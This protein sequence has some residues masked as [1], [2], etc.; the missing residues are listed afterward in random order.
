MGFI[1]GP[2]KHACLERCSG[3]RHFLHASRPSFSTN[4]RPSAG[5]RR[6]V[7]TRHAPINWP[8]DVLILGACGSARSSTCSG[9]PNLARNFC[10]PPAVS[11]ELFSQAAD[12]HPVSRLGQCVAIG[13]V[14]LV[15]RYIA[16]SDPFNATAFALVRASSPCGAGTLFMVIPCPARKCGGGPCARRSPHHVK[17]PEAHARPDDTTEL[18]RGRREIAGNWPR[19]GSPTSAARSSG[20]MTNLRF[21]DGDDESYQR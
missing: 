20:G 8:C 11:E 14:L 15:Q 4:S 21:V 7:A 18:P 6:L 16:A 5:S 3:W 13:V 12:E 9:V 17:A 2:R 19:A 1:T 10:R